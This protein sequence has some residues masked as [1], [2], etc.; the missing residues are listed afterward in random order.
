MF[1]IETTDTK[2]FVHKVIHILHGGMHDMFF[3][4]LHCVKLTYEMKVIKSQQTRMHAY[5]AS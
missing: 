2:F 1:F 5:K 3:Y 4:L